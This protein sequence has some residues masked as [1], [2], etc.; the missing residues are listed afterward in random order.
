MLYQIDSKVGG[1]VIRKYNHNIDNVFFF[2]D[3]ISNKSE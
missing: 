2:L 3:L 1:Q